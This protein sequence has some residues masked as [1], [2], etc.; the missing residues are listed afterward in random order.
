[1]RSAF[2]PTWET[3][4]VLKGHVLK[5]Y[6]Q[7]AQPTRPRKCVVKLVSAELQ[8]ASIRLQAWNK[9]R[10]MSNFMRIFALLSHPK[11]TVAN[12]SNAGPSKENQNK[13]SLKSQNN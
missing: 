13:K 7:H 3:R 8:H 4:T 2:I 6:A 12:R 1:M 11:E 9:T 10:W 5:T